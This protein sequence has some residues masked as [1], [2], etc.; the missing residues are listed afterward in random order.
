MVAAAQP[1]STG[2]F[3]VIG[4]DASRKDLAVRR[5]T[6]FIL[7]N[8]DVGKFRRLLEGNGRRLVHNEPVSTVRS[9]YFD[10]PSLSDLSLIHI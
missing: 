1:V 7:P 10:D 2:L 8:A 9:V 3:N 5:E 4:E 6:K